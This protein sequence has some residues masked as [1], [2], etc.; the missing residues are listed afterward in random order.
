MRVN[1][2]TGLFTLDQALTQPLSPI[3]WDVEPL[4]AHGNRVV[5]YG[6]F[7]CGKSWVLLDLGLHLALGIDWLDTFKVSRPQTVLYIDEEMSKRTLQT[8]LHQITSGLGAADKANEVRFYWC[9]H[10]GLKLFSRLAVEDLLEQ[11]KGMGIVPD[12]VIVETLRRVICGSENEASDV[13]RMW[14]A[15]EPFVE[16]NTTFILSHHMKKPNPKVNGSARHKFSGSTDIL[17]GADSG[18]AIS[19]TAKDGLT[20]ECVKL[21]DAEESEPF[22]IGLFDA[23]ERA[24]KAVELRYL[25]T[26]GG[27]EKSPLVLAEGVK[28]LCARTVPGAEYR[29]SDLLGFLVSNFSQSTAER[30]VRECETLGV[31]RKVSHGRYCRTAQAVLSVSTG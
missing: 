6:E 16:T 14:E 8:R 21:R 23:P 4:I 26:K 5:V 9:S 30:A 19:K 24:A 18:Y 7:G 17:A 20:I 25:G 12:V 29:T 2:K 10:L 1:V 31:F 22:A 13:G 15:A 28:A 3:D 27:V 11:L